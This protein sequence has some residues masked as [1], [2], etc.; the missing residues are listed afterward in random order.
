LGDQIK[1]DERAGY[2]ERMTEMRK[3]YNILVAKSEGK[4]LLG[5]PR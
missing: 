1:E 3:V 5:G 2:A 4:I